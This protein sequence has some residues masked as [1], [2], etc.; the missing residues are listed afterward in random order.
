MAPPFLDCSRTLGDLQ[1]TEQRITVR[2]VLLYSKRRSGSGPIVQ[3]VYE[4]IGVDF[5]LLVPKIS[6]RR[7][8]PDTVFHSA[9]TTIEWKG[10][11]VLSV[12]GR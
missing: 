12:M 2:L 5:I 3:S 11:E 1:T 4:S 9:K 8:K 7:L 6:Q 10:N